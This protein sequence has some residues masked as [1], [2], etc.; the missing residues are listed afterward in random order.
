MGLG[1]FFINAPSKENRAIRCGMRKMHNINII[2][3]S[4]RLTKIN[5]YMA[6]FPCSD[7]TNKICEAYIKSILLHSIPNG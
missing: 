4:C 7:V 3:Y 2:N 6:M 5:Y 1:T